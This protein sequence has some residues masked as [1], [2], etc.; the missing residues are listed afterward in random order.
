MTCNKSN[1]FNS[2]ESKR[3]LKISEGKKQND[4]ADMKKN[5]IQFL[6]VKNI[7]I[8]IEIQLND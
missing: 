6:A 8:K 5:K 3:S 2:F 7:N 1:L 4:Q